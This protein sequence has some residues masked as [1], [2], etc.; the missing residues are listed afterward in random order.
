MK[1]R[2]ESPAFEQA[3]EKIAKECNKIT[4]HK[5]TMNQNNKHNSGIANTI[6]YKS[7]L[8][9]LAW[10]RFIVKIIKEFKRP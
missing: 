10:K 8:A 6:Y 4:T 3:K 7:K 1:F 5:I 9:N 2:F